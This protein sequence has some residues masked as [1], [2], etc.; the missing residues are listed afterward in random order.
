MRPVQGRGHARTMEEEEGSTSDTSSSSSFPSPCTPPPSPST[1][2]RLTEAERVLDAFTLWMTTLAAGL[3]SVRA[4]H[5]EGRVTEAALGEVAT[6]A[7]DTVQFLWASE[8]PAQLEA[9]QTALLATDE[10]EE[11]DEEEG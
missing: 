4:A 6:C 1:E 11:E 9:L 2:E 10:D 3:A 8:V 7:Y 5:A